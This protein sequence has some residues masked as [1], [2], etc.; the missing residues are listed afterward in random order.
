MRKPR[1]LVTAAAGKTGAPTAL[2]LL[3]KGYPVRAL[4]RQVDARAERLRRAGAEITVGSF[5]DF[6]DLKRALQDINRAYFCPPLEPGTL[7]RAALFA[8]AAREARLEAIVQL[9]QWLA[10]PIHPAAH[11][12]EKWLTSQ[13][14]ERLS[15]VATCTIQPGWFADN[16][17]AVIGQA[18]QFG[19][20]ALPLG[21]GLNAPP[22]NEDI[23]RV[24][25]AC[26]V[27]PTS[28]AGM[29]YRPT[30]PR[31]LAP[32]DI[33]GAMG[34][35]LGR[36]VRYRNVP[37][38]MFLKAATSLGVSDFVTPQLYWFLQDYQLNA[39]GVGAPTGVVEELTG[40]APEDFDTIARRYARASP[41]AVRSFLGAIHEAVGLAAALVSRAPDIG[42]IE[43]RFALPRI[44]NFALAAN[45]PLWRATHAL[46]GRLAPAELSLM[47]AASE[48]L[49]A[50]QPRPP[51]SADR[52][53]KTT[54][55][56]INDERHGEWR[57]EACTSTSNP[58]AFAFTNPQAATNLGST[59]NC[60]ANSR[61][62]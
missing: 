43:T 40:N 25:V 60:S 1:I 56:M 39:F 11:A 59:F 5:E 30:G 44:G 55:T 35:A 7:R 48:E 50:N 29:A 57:S 16:Y 33:A 17:F 53:R 36:R 27:D 15:G 3:E 9:N 22:S 46:G 26:L 24:V 41:L 58:A 32:W 10:D 13:M 18:A 54:R 4:V 38:P 12:R 28:H 47:P 45:S 23:V 14:L 62:L 21:E 52:A 19:L 49:P 34:R 61:P 2:G 20:L 8:T 37:L 42:R 6:R 31:L 51:E